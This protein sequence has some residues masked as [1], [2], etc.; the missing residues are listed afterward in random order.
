MPAKTM[1]IVAI[2]HRPASC[3]RTSRP[4]RS[5]EVSAKRRDWA[6]PAP[7]VLPSSTPLT[8]SPSSTWACRS[9]R[10]RWRCAVTVRR[11]R[12]TLRVSTTAGGRTSNDSSDSRHDSATMATI[13][14]TTVVA[15]DARDVAVEVTTDCMPEMSWVS[16]DCTSPPRVRVKKPS[17]WRCRWLNTEVRRP[18]MTR[19]PTVVDS[20]VCT[21]PRTAVVAATASM[22][23]TAQTSSRTSCRGSASSMTSLTRNGVASATRDEVTMSTTTVATCQRNG[24]NSAVTR[25]SGTGLR[26]SWARSAGSRVRPPPLPCPLES[27]MTTTSRVRC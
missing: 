8:L 21:T 17:D 27:S 19:C 18:C 11:I 12:A 16:R 23:R 10:W 22:P 26:S 5:A 13:V 4:T 9:A 25:R 14:P 3:A 24:A 1:L 6:G 2:R 15:L 7:R 20:Q